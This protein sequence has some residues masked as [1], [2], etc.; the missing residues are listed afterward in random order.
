MKALARRLASLASY[1]PRQARVIFVAHDI[2]N[3]T[4][5]TFSPGNSTAPELFAR[6]L[7]FLQERFHFVPLEEILS[8]E[9]TQPM[10]SLTFDDGFLTVRTRAAAVLAKKSIPFALFCNRK[11]ISEGKLDYDAEYAP[12]PPTSARI[13][14]DASEIKEFHRSGALIGSHGATH[15]SLA[16]VPH[17]RLTDEID[18]NKA[19][20]EDL[21]GQDVFHFAFPYG[22]PRHITHKAMERARAAGHK[23]LYSATPAYLSAEPC[24]NASTLIPRVSLHNQNERDLHL[25]LNKL[26]FALATG[27]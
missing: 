25:L 23:H 3:S 8:Q 22:K 6:Q 21:L 24:E 2:S 10:A 9:N 4:D 15:A 14:L 1:V 13:Y 26:A 27:G 11:A 16:K 19:F 17:E 20:L 7:A 18:G 12:L 5:A